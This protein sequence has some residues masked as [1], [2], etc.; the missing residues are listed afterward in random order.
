M[1]RV[2]NTCHRKSCNA[3]VFCQKR[4]LRQPG[5]ARQA[6][7]MSTNIRNAIFSKKRKRLRQ[8]SRPHQSW[9]MSKSLRTS[10]LAPTSACGSG[11]TSPKLIHVKKSEE[12]NLGLKKERLRQPGRSHQSWYY[13]EIAEI[14][15]WSL[16]GRARQPERPH[17]TSTGHNI[18]R[19]LCN[20]CK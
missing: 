1:Q 18:P 2:F 16:K 5:R 20:I 17:Q 8:P 12:H 9:Y 7:Y 11:K 14:S 15:F 10:L 19:T 3:F 13:R 6:W 4:G